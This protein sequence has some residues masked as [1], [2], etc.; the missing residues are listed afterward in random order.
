MIMLCNGIRDGCFRLSFLVDLT[1]S[2]C[3]CV[4]PVLEGEVAGKESSKI[5]MHLHDGRVL[6]P[7]RSYMHKGT[8]L[9]HNNKLKLKL[10]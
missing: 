7:P 10:S 9:T 1:R 8:A 4:G 5:L 3:C 6:R 2:R